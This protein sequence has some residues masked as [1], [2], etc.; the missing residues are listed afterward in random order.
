MAAFRSLVED[1]KLA[2]NF[3]DG[4]F[5]AS[6]QLRMASWTD[7]IMEI[8]Q[9]GHMVRGSTDDNHWWWRRG[10]LMSLDLGTRAV[11]ILP[12]ATWIACVIA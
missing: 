7:L 11:S 5:E 8:L 6:R 4:V 1:I 3:F 10:L 12:A 9:P 2:A